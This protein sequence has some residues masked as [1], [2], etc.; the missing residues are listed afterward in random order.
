MEIR[1]YLKDGMKRTLCKRM[2]FHEEEEER[3]GRGGG[4]GWLRKMGF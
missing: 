1:L 4:E 3:K 2:K